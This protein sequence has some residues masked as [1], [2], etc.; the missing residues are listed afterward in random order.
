MKNKGWP[1]AWT[2]EVSQLARAMYVEHYKGKFQTRT[3]PVCLQLC[4]TSSAY[5]MFQR[6]PKRRKLDDD[7]PTITDPLDRWLA[8]TEPVIELDTLEDMGGPLRFWQAKRGSREYNAD[9]CQMAIDIL[10]TPGESFID[11][12]LRDSCLNCLYQPLPWTVSGCSATEDYVS[13]ICK[14]THFPTPSKHERSWVH[15]STPAF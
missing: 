1:R 4:F 11:L 10:S 14:P 9:L 8:N 2:N 13:T 5:A 6:K 3:S 12:P 15:G 7:A